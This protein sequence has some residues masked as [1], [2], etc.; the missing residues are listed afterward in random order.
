M[1]LRGLEIDLKNFKT[2]SNNDDNNCKQTVVVIPSQ[3]KIDKV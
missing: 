3:T 1:T 2:A